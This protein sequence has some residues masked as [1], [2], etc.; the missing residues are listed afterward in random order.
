MVAWLFW[1]QDALLLLVAVQILQMVKQLS[2]V[3]RADGYHILSDATGIPDLYAH[4][5]PTLRRLLPGH[6]REPT[7]LTGKARLLVTVWVLIVVPVLLSLMLGAILLLP[8]LATTAWESGRR[9][10]VLM[11]HQASNFQL[12]NLGASALRL[13][14]LLLPVIGS[15]LVAQKV[16]R[17]AVAKA[18]AWS[19]G[20]THRRLLVAVVGAGLIALLAWAWWPSGQYTPVRPNQRGTIPQLFHL[21]ASRAAETRAAQPTDP[22]TPDPRQ[23]AVLLSPG[24]HLAL[25]MVPA[26]GATRNHPAVYILPA[27]NGHKAAELLSFGKNTQPRVFPFALP[28][29][30][31]PGDTQALAVNTKDGS[32]LYDL[33]YAV[34][35]VSG[36]D[37]VTNTNSAYAIAQ[38]RDCITDAVS[39]QV[40]LIVGQSNYITPING[41]N[42]L[43]YRCLLCLTT[44][45]AD[46]IIV[47]LQSQ[48]SPALISQLEAALAQLNLLPKLGANGTP[49]ALAAAVGAIQQQVVTVLNQSG[50]LAGQPVT[51]TTIAGTGTTPTSIVP[52]ST[53]SATTAPATTPTVATP[54]TT[55]TVSGS[56]S[57]TT[58]AVSPTTTGTSATSV[59]GGA[60]TS[61]TTAATTATTQGSTATTAP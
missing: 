46:Q 47:T 32:V 36:G 15:A 38:C 11:P 61:A 44:A 49:A 57:P 48:P 56:V 14:A 54:A 2:P 26:G 50:L 20:R 9:I 1:R 25:A 3:I 43:N 55:D 23:P 24:S 59:G 60:P 17:S 34:V 45:I 13:F 7:A 33:A 12:V 10:A 6:R 30:P 29:P 8:H 42:A 28:A 35:T 16:V 51:A 39:F 22:S 52:A 21:D 19:A 40:V 41:A 37:P 5:G 4:V 58:A 31:G 27:A 53:G 18:L